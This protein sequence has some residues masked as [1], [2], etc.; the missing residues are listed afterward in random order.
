MKVS[1][2]AVLQPLL[3]PALAAM[4]ALVLAACGTAT[5]KPDRPAPPVA[6]APV[7]APDKGDPQARFQAALEQL[8]AKQ[9]SEAEA[10]LV[11]LSKDFPEFS[12][13]WTNLGIIYANSNRKPLAMAAFNKAAVLNQEN[14]VAF[15]WL[16]ILSRET[17]DYARAQAAYERVLKLQPNHA[18]AHYNL[19][20]LLDEHLK[21]PADAL[22]HYREY[23]R[24]AGKQDLKVLA[25]VAEIEATAARQAPAPTVPATAAPATAPRAATRSNARP[26]EGAR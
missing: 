16:G 6:G 12:G 5:R 2:K 21:R 7:K 4:L 18:L 15:N 11:A 13:P 3:K 22:P 1:G 25:W 24:L 17:R 8:K 14:A 19:A 9:F 20:I 10:A 23:Q 26:A